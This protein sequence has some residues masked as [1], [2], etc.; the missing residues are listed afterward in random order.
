MQIFHSSRRKIN[1]TIGIHTVFRGLNLFFQ[2]GNWGNWRCVTSCRQGFTLLEILIAISIFAVVIA[3]IFSTFK[4]FIVSSEG[5]KADVLQIETITN[6]YKRI[7]LDFES[8][9]V[10][11]KPRYKKPGFDSEP[12]PYSFTGSEENIGQKTVSSL[13]F[14]SLAHAKFGD[15]QR[16]GVAKIIYYVREN[17]NKS[18]DLCRADILPPFSDEITSCT[19]PVLYKDI[20][21]FEVV[22][23]DFSGDEFRYWDSEAQEFNYTFPSTVDLKL[24]F[25][26]SDQ[27]QVY[28]M[29]F[30]IIPQR[31]P[32]E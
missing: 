19:D 20:S 9:F 21:G 16:K 11:Q 27:Q 1:L 3:T 10:L 15:D 29:S 24:T 22:Y 7:S 6:V 18:L 28:L 26:A 8:I 30:D 17:E 23:K 13:V 2:R 32:I 12:D 14:S 4:A 5:V 31:Q 25:G